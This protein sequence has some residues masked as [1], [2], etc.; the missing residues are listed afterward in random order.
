MP[1]VSKGL[2][3]GQSQLGTKIFYNNYG[4]LLHKLKMLDTI[5]SVAWSGQ[6]FDV[7]FFTA[8]WIYSLVF[9]YPALLRQ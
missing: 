3:N 2:I 6:S 1:M 5:I 4:E 7:E 9:T 8:K